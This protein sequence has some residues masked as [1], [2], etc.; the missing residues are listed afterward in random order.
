MFSQEKNWSYYISKIIKTNVTSS[1]TV[2]Q[3]NR[4]KM[5]TPMMDLCWY[6]WEQ[7]LEQGKTI[8]GVMIDIMKQ[9]HTV[10][11]MQP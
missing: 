6:P 5:Q 1:E 2:M 7:E 8:L 3:Q 9:L 4:E 11:I 10:F